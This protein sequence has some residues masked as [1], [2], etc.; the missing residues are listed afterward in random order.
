MRILIEQFGGTIGS[1]T[2]DDGIVRL[3]SKNPAGD[4]AS[5]FKDI[6]FIFSSRLKY[7]SENATCGTFRDAIRQITEDI[8]DISPD[9][10]L[11]LHGTDTMSFFAQLA[12]RCLSY[13]G[14]PFVITGSKLPPDQDGTDAYANVRGSI[15]L[16]RTG[17]RLAHVVFSKSSGGDI[18][19]IP[20][21]LVTAADINGDYGRFPGGRDGAGET[22]FSGDNYRLRAEKFVRSGSRLGIL[23]IPA[24]PGYPYEA[25]DAGYY[26]NIIICCYH[27]GTANSVILP[28]KVREW[29]SD[30]IR[31]Y[32]APVPAGG[33]IYESRSVLEEAGAIPVPGIPLE[34]CWA[35]VLLN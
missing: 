12:V 29:T 8:R 23:V 19:A 3:D 26:R 2:G 25:I 5:G 15:E 6:E 30:G 31:C 11:V 9:A 27:S 10:V 4:L 34:G 14:I 7:S 13:T 16:L 20:C 17:K 1:C 35:E 22:D 21:S 18:E 33:N 24:V 28:Q 32:L